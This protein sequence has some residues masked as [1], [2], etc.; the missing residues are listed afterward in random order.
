M[1]YKGLLYYYYSLQL[2]LFSKSDWFHLCGLI[3]DLGKMMAIWGED[4]Y[5]VVGDTFPVG[6]KFS[7]TI[8]YSDTTFF[9]N[10]DLHDRRYK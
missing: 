1:I 8:V 5:C 6:C 3:H 9:N 4:Q 10:P 2:I 7:S